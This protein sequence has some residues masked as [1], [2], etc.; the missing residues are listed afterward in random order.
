MSPDGKWLAYASDESGS[1]EVYVRPFPDVTA[2]RRQVSFGGGVHPAWNPAG[3]ELF[4]IADAVGRSLVARLEDELRSHG[5]L[6]LWVGT[7]DEA[8]LTSLGGVDLYPDL[9]VPSPEEDDG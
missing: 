7:D 8:G 9:L 6:T 4:F 2:G 3:G 5:A 1:F